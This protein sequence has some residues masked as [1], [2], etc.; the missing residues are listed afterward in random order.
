[1]SNELGD[2]EARAQRALDGMTVNLERLATDTMKLCRAVRHLTVEVQRLTAQEIQ[3]G[4]KDR[5]EVGDL[6][7][8][9]GSLGKGAR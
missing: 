5:G 3:P 2:I 6:F 4:S 1:M 8:L 7:D 9:F